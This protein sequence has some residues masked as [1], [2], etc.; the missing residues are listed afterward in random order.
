MRA[1]NLSFEKTKQLIIPA[2]EQLFN[3]EI[4][5]IESNYLNPRFLINCI[6]ELIG[7]ID[8]DFD[9]NGWEYDYWIYFEYEGQKYCI[10]G[11]GYNGRLTL[12]REEDEE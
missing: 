11:T 5:S 8:T 9:C 2:L 12:S 6:E 4:D 10:S 1:F 7:E 3:G